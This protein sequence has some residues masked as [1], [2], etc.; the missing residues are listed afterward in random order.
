MSFPKKINENWLK[1]EALKETYHFHSCCCLNRKKITVSNRENNFDLI[2][3][4]IEFVSLSPSS[5]IFLVAPKGG[6]KKRRAFLKFHQE[7][8]FEHGMKWKWPEWA[9][10]VF[11]SDACLRGSRLR[12]HH[13]TIYLLINPINVP[14]I[15]PIRPQMIEWMYLWRLINLCLLYQNYISIRGLAKWTSV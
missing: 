6:W 3:W 9:K 14:N 11:Y 2:V 12:F 1:K 4:W 15:K 5:I 7:A 10:A 13:L 8:P